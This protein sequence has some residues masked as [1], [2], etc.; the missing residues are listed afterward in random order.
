[1]Q[2]K[3]IFNN[4]L[5]NAYGKNEPPLPPLIAK[6]F[7]FVSSTGLR[8]TPEILLLEL[9]RET[10]FDRFSSS[11]GSVQLDPERKGLYSIEEKAILYLTRGRAKKTKI[12]NFSGYFAPAYP[13]LAR[14]GW[15]RPKS[16]R[17][18][19]DAIFRGFIAQSLRDTSGKLIPVVAKTIINS[20]EGFRSV[21]SKGIANAEILSA[22]IANTIF[23]EKEFGL[24]SSEEATARTC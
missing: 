10:F 5:G 22:A 1:M 17:Q 11:K 18:L 2:N 14:G 15:L 6:S 8:E 13:S 3:D 21:E 16:D 24:L 20:L 23:D 12:Q 7:V 9:F 4:L 19:R